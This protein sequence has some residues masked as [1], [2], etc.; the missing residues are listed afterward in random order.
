MKHISFTEENA[1]KILNPFLEYRKYETRRTW[2][3]RKLRAG[4]EVWGTIKWWGGTRFATL[5]ILADPIQERLAEMDD[6]AAQREGCRNLRE[7]LETQFKPIYGHTYGHTQVWVVKFEVVLITPEGRE[8]LKQNK[9]VNVPDGVRDT[10]ASDD[11]S[12]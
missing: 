5:K 1:L 10:S 2:K 8:L 6:Y 12:T 4:D 7:Y 11:E 3:Q 9:N